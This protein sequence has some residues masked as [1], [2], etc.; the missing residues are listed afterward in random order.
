VIFDMEG[1]S[2]ISDF[3]FICHG[4]STAHTRGIADKISLTV[5]KEGELPLGIEGLEEG[6]WILIDYNSV[7]VHIFLKDVRE[8]YTLEEI[9]STYLKKE[10]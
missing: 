8:Q 9:Y 5:K 3:V 10:I 7:I 2:S 4:T 6:Q 1:K